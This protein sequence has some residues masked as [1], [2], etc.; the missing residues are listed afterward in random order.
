MK[1]CTQSFFQNHA[2]ITVQ[3]G[4]RKIFRRIY[5]LFLMVTLLLN[6]VPQQVSAAYYYDGTYLSK[7]YPTA[8]IPE[9]IASGRAD[10]F[11]ANI[12]GF[13]I[14]DIVDMD[15][16]EHF[17]E[18]VDAGF[19]DMRVFVTHEKG[20]PDT[21]LVLVYC[22]KNS[23]WLLK[24][25]TRVLGSIYVEAPWVAPLEQF[26]GLD[27][28]L[29]QQEL[30]NLLVPG[31]D[32]NYE[33]DSK[34]VWEAYMSLVV[35]VNEANRMIDIYMK[36]ATSYVP[37]LPDTINEWPLS[38]P[39]SVQM[40]AELQVLEAFF[41]V[42]ATGNADAVEYEYADDIP[43]S[44]R[45][46]G[47]IDE[48]NLITGTVLV[49][50]PG[51]HLVRA[52][53]IIA[54]QNFDELLRYSIHIDTSK[55]K[56]SEGSGN[57]AD[58]DENTESNTAD[59]EAVIGD[60]QEYE[61]LHDATYLSEVE[62]TRKFAV[63]P[64]N[65]M[66]HYV[67][68]SEYLRICRDCKADVTEEKIS[69][70]YG[71]NNTPYTDIHTPGTDGKCIFCGYQLNDEALYLGYLKEDKRNSI[72]P[73]YDS[74]V[75]D[76][77]WKRFEDAGF[78]VQQWKEIYNVLEKAPEKYRDIY[79]F[80]FFSYISRGNLQPETEEDICNYDGYTDILSI[81]DNIRPD[82]SFSA[83]FFHESGHA[84]QLHLW[85]YSLYQS[86][87]ID[88]NNIYDALA[89]TSPFFEIESQIMEDLS[90]DVRNHIREYIEQKKMG[91]IPVVDTLSNYIRYIDKNET[92]TS[93]S[94][95]QQK[96]DALVEDMENYYNN[97]YTNR[98]SSSYY[99]LKIQNFDFRSR[100]ETL[101]K[102]LEGITGEPYFMNYDGEIPEPI[103]EPLV[104]ALQYA[105][106]D[107]KDRD[108]SPLMEGNNILDAIH[109]NVDSG[110]EYEI[111]LDCNDVVKR[112]ALQGFM[113]SDV[114]GGVTNQKIT[115]NQGHTGDDYWF[116]DGRKETYRQLREGW[117][118]FFSSKINGDDETIR[119]N[120]E[121]FPLATADME[122][123]ADEILEYYRNMYQ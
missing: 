4:K 30:I 11:F 94:A 39:V 40:P 93:L 53:I 3:E 83:V 122:I 62:G 121:Y 103:R 22:F 113:V 123:L 54:V 36:G 18:A 51:P 7:Y 84:V 1:G 119:L 31:N 38:I 64:G 33:C 67:T 71:V 101:V 66:R 5:A 14:T 116:N 96:V 86:K 69:M 100:Y 27:L 34:L 17:G 25:T 106:V 46:A 111:N 81:Y 37:P 41:I 112:K 85:D 15:F 19:K 61:C 70:T 102:E 74:R 10:T 95:L 90:Q 47:T 117:A 63:M 75:T 52:F 35:Y 120:Y 92:N 91:S 32:G 56:L 28:N 48:N 2:I 49:W 110:I 59:P 24:D 114:Y 13:A 65:D 82:D 80:S 8:T 9:G 72:N 23:T 105:Y 45:F 97:N 60:Q 21:D 55:V 87:T 12:A 107:S 26:Q 109:Y 58:S 108:L 99:P 57:S 20:M 29:N 77:M 73:M 68:Y 42:D 118:E 44:K 16:F 50:E 88:K 89:K 76:F 104:E 115:G 6:I 43:D 78:T 98:I 79:P